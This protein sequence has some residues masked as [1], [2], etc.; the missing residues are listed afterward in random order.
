MPNQ[1][2]GEVAAHLGGRDFTLC[3]TLGALAEI[4]TAFGVSGLDALG[5]RLA[6]G[7]LSAGD[8]AAII[9]AAARGGGHD[10]TS[11]EIAALPIAGGLQPYIDAVAALFAATFPPVADGATAEGAAG[12]PRP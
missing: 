3:L 12:K 10:V 5:E 2:R 11:A 9:A 6:R 7:A 1:R 4:E 8:L